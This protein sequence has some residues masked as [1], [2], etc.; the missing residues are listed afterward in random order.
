MRAPA[1]GAHR[2]ED[3]E[4]MPPLSWRPMTEADLDGVVA[5]AAEAFPDHPEDRA[6]F[7]NRLALYPNGCRVLGDTAEAVAGYLVGYPWMLDAAPVLNT[8]L[9][10]LPEEANVYYLHD[11]ALTARV[12]GAGHAA[13][14]A[15]LAVQAARA[16]GLGAVSLTAVNG[17]APFWARQGF[18][19]RPSHA[20]AA[21]LVS[22]GEDAV[23]M[24]RRI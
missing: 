17:A 7:A 15:A 8:L 5:V 10:G 6:C 12:R 11:L 9:P 14:G 19:P 21:K 22:Y 3:G 23:Y 20:M 2:P 1:P 4:L 13:Q 24:I 18:E 16:A